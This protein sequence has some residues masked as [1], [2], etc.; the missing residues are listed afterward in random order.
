MINTEDTTS[1]PQEQITEE[2]R[3]IPDTNDDYGAS[4]LG[5][6]RRETDGHQTYAGRILL[7]TISKDGYVKVGVRHKGKRITQGAHVLVALAFIGPC[8]EGMEVNH[9]DGIKTNN[10]PDNLE[11]K[12]HQENMT[13]A[14]DVIDVI[15]PTRRRGD[16][17]PKRLHPELIA[18][19]KDHWATRM[20]EKYKRG[21]DCHASKVKE[22]DV[23]EILKGFDNVRGSLSRVARKYGMSH[24]AVKAIV[25]GRTWAHVR[26][27]ILRFPKT[28]INPSEA[29]NATTIEGEWGGQGLGCQ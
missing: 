23:I 18:R 28:M 11:Y 12:T 1:Q 6:V 20:P 9:K 13:H 7:G 24:V 17:H 3:I 26:P 2:W 29:R 21:A 22:A 8:P 16:N 14:R 25:T 27:D 4:S 10:W 15:I 19:G 5:R